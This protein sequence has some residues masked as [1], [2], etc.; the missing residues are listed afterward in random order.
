M[1]GDT[2]ALAAAHKEIRSHFYQSANVT[3]E[4]DISTLCA[5]GKDA[6]NFLRTAVVQGQLNERGNFG[7]AL[8]W[9]C[10]RGS[11]QWPAWINVATSRRA[12]HHM[13]CCARQPALSAAL[14]ATWTCLC[15]ILHCIT[16]L[17]CSNAFSTAEI[18]D[19]PAEAGDSVNVRTPQQESAS[20]GR[21]T[22]R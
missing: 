1:K 16:N 4:A 2:P 3:D 9:Q 8:L 5:Q 19:I 13:C 15:E 20:N 11:C 22:G 14:N 17:Q 7:A 18:K 21:K 6:A 12:N 10:D